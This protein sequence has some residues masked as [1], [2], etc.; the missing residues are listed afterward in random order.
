MILGLEIGMLIAGILAISRG[1]MELTPS[2]VA[3]GIAARLLGVLA[4]TPLPAAI[5]VLT[6]YTGINC[7]GKSER[8]IAMWVEQKRTNMII[9]E[10][11]VVLMIALLVVG[12]IALCSDDQP[13][14]PNPDQQSGDDYPVVPRRY[15]SSTEPPM[16]PV[17]DPS[18]PRGERVDP[19]W[20]SLSAASFQ[21][22]VRCPHCRE[23]TVVDNRELGS[24]VIC[25][26]CRRVYLAP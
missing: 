1:R 10:A 2:M 4:M 25:P 5:V 14:K 7:V 20:T 12:G 23:E 11:G 19:R 24:N 26:A 21:T 13:A 16:A 22:V 15:T 17:S 3:H 9:L 8:E 18:P 6:I